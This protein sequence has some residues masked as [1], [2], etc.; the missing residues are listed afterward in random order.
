MFRLILILAAVLVALVAAGCSGSGPSNPSQA[1]VG[2]V[3]SPSEP[4][5]PPIEVDAADYAFVMPD[6]IKGGVVSMRFRN[7]GKELHEFA[8][9]RIGEGHTVD[10]VLAA[11]QKSGDDLPWLTDMAGPPLLTPGAEIGITRKLDPGTYAFLCYVP[12]TK[13]VPHVQLGMT[14]KFTVA[15]D[16]GAE[17]RKPDALIT[18]RAKRFVVPNLRAG[19]QT[20]ELRN[21]SG[22][23][24]GFILTTFN[25]GKTEADAE[26]WFGRIE[27]S[28]R[29]PRTPAPLTGLGA[30]QSIPNGTSVYLTVDLE[31][32]RTYRLTEDE[33]GF[34]TDFTPR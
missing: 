8:L 5:P 29:L 34:E 25:P 2:Q 17:L 15:G 18:A 30:I 10:D 31:A 28:G 3:S 16:S 32:G 24:R 21:A 9:V 26:R 7:T 1:T 12:N 27:S 19:R 22:G 13:G 4:S 33:H 11:L 20:I 23:E 6:R 14:R